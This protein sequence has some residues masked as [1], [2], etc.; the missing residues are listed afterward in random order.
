MKLI[1][2]NIAKVAVPSGKNE[3]I[4]FDDDIPGL[5]LRVRIGGSRNWIFQYRI[6]SKQRRLSLGSAKAISAQ[7]AR[8][9]A[10]ELHARTK[11][12]QD[13]AGERIESRAKVV[14]T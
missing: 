4:V 5:G 7:S 3:I 8:T 9:R 10:T 12:G 2:V 6:G 1:K 14:E 13:V 11:L